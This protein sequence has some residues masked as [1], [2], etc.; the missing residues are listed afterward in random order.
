MVH[1]NPDNN[2]ET[3]CI[4][5]PLFYIGVKLGLPLLGRDMD[6]ECFKKGFEKIILT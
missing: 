6:F 4:T 2:L 3:P 5:L 1:G